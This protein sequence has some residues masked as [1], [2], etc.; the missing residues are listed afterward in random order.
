MISFFVEGI[1]A[2]GGS[3]NGFALKKGG[4]Y[5][6]RVA[7]VDAGGK[8]NK[9][10]RATVA[11]EARKLN[12]AALS[13]TALSVGM[14]FRMPR[15]KSHYN[16]KGGLVSRATH[17]HIQKPDVLKLARSTEDA[18]TSIIWQDDSTTIKLTLSKAWAAIG[19]KS[20]CHITIQ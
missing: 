3:K 6:G 9:L 15:P 7:M 14:D 2:P 5:T 11:A 13:T 8:K 1:P 12:V 20:G 4:F 16:S 17:D 10:W 19:E 18:L